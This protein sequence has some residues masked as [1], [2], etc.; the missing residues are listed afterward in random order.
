MQMHPESERRFAIR[1]VILPILLGVCFALGLGL[2]LAAAP[3]DD[4][5]AKSSASSSPRRLSAREQARVELGRRLFYEPQASKSGAVSCASCHA[6]D[7][8]FSDPDRQSI[9]DV[10]STPRHSQTII[11]SAHNPTVHW[12]GEFGSVEELVSRRLGTDVVVYYGNEFTPPRRPRGPVTP[13]VIARM[14]GN[15]LEDGVLG[16]PGRR[17]FL[18][19][20]ALA[21]T[22]RSNVPALLARDGRYAEAFKA[23]FGNDTP[24]LER[25]SLAIAAFCYTLDSTE[26]PYD[27]Y[28]SGKKKAISDQAKRGLTLF[29]GRAGCADCHTVEGKHPLFTDFAFHNTGLVFE[30]LRTA[31]TGDLITD[32]KGRL[33]RRPLKNKPLQPIAQDR[34][35][36]RLTFKTNH[37]RAFKTPTLR[38]VTKRGP[39]MHDG[40]FD[41]LEDVVRWY[42]AGCGTDP[43]KDH[44]LGRFD[45]DEKDVQ[46]L[47]AFLKTLEGHERPGLAKKAWKRRAAKTRLRIVQGD[48][49]VADIDVKLIPVGDPQPLAKPRSG[50][51]LTLR[52]DSNGEVVFTP[53]ATTHMRVVLP[54][55][56]PVLNNALVPDTCRNATMK[57]PLVGRMTFVVTFPKEFRAPPVLVA[58][59]PTS[60]PA[61][62]KRRTVFKRGEVVEMKDRRVAKYVGWV[63]SDLPRSVTLR[64]PGMKRNRRNP[65]MRYASL[66]VTLEPGITKRIDLTAN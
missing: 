58:D 54:D 8:G 25:I 65:S 12:D 57:V 62:K 66:A 41:K 37:E 43:K 20:F 63:R 1:R 40:R 51:T 30:S 38:D 2:A 53:A 22:L 7:H 24:T 3:A 34:G 33:V 27:Q 50:K 35:L 39:F 5:V 18:K 28:R 46:D 4:A 16:K 21:Q 13:R 64:L 49:P 42:A 9:D 11:D 19:E 48:V 6:P 31:S 26:S 36:A 52:T 23:A 44:R 55:D 10:G 29:V 15:L 14:D 32:D 61:A 59:H 17:G 47:I 45:C 60:S 56:I